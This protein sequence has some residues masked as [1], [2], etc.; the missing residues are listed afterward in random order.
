MPAAAHTQASATLASERHRRPH[1]LDVPSEHDR[2]RVSVN[3]TVPHPTRGVILAISREDDAGATEPRP[4]S[5]RVEHGHVVAA[6]SSGASN[7]PTS[8]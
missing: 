7:A 8:P 2:G 1:V 3:A 4:Q 5:L 6:E